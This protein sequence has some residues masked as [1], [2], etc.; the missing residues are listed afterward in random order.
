MKKL[1]KRQIIILVIMAIAIIYAAYDFLIGQP[2]VKK[3]KIEAT[4]IEIESFITSISNDVMKNKMAGVEV[5]IIK[6]AEADWGRNPFWMRSEYRE[7]AG[8]E[9]GG[10]LAAKIVYSGYVDSGR[11]RMAIINGYEYEP[12]DVLEIEGYVLKSVTP[13]RVLIANPGTGSELFIPL[14]E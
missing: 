2:A 3:A 9:A 11:K 4:P 6:K 10:G 7:F 12:G 1:N 13:S 14:Q 5:Y 8:D